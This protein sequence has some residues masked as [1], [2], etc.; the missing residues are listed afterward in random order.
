MDGKIFSSN[1][2]HVAVVIGNVIFNLKGEKVYRL[3]GANIYR[4]TGELV[5]HLA[6]AGGAEKRLDK[7]TDKLF[8]A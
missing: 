1:G 7:A 2:D 3:Q 6:N 8:D 4:M 5:G